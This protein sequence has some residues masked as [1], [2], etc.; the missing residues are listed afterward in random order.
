M[1]E[2]AKQRAAKGLVEG[3]AFRAHL[4]AHRGVTVSGCRFC[5]ERNANRK[6][7]HPDSEPLPSDPRAA[8][9][10]TPPTMNDT[11]EWLHSL[12]SD[13]RHHAS[14]GFLG[15][16]TASSYADD[17]LALAAR[18]SA[19]E[20][21]IAGLRAELATTAKDYVEACQQVS[22]EREESAGLR[23]ALEKYGQHLGTCGLIC[24]SFSSDCTC[25]L[26]AA[27]GVR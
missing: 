10:E 14:G 20:G 1:S 12:A 18:L 4:E 15:V 13:L 6:A 27:P 25:G 9:R 16:G 19:H 21:E 24:G 5:A 3:D 17:A 26:Y 8:P 2:T 23:E 7:L 11:V 22:R